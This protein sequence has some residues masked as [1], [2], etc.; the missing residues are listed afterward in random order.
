MNNSLHHEYR[1]LTR[2][3]GKAFLLSV[4]A[5]DCRYELAIKPFISTGDSITLNPTWATAKFALR[6]VDL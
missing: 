2:R 5:G 4:V 1:F 3:D 6:I